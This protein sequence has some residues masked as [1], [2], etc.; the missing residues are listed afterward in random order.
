FREFF[1]EERRSRRAACASKALGSCTG[2]E[3]RRVQGFS[4]MRVAVI[5]SGISGLAAAR[6]LDQAGVATVLFEAEPRFGGHTATVDVTL[7]GVTA[8]VDT[9][10]LVC[11]DHTYPNLLALFAELGVELAS[12]DMSFSVRADAADVEWAGATLASVFAQ[13]ANLFRPR[14]WRFLA[15]ILRFNREATRMVE[16]GAIPEGSVERYLREAGYGGELF[17]WYLWPMVG[18]IWSSPKSEVAEFE[19]AM[20]LR[21]SHNHGLLRINH[22]PRWMTVVGGGRTYVERIVAALPD[23]R[24]ACPVMRIDRQPGGVWVESRHGRERFDHVVFACHSDQALAILGAGAT[25]AERKALGAIRYQPNRCVL[26]TDRS[27]MPRRNTAWSAWNYLQT[28]ADR[29]ADRPVTL[30]YWLNRLQ[31]LPFSRPLFET[32]NPPRDPAPGHLI[33]AFE[34]AHPLLN[35]TAVAAQAEV[36]RLQGQNNTW[37]AGAWLGYG[38]HEDGLKSGLAAARGVIESIQATTAAEPPRLAAE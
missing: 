29:D 22:R 2:H 3:G 25:L 37:F 31:P 27:F 14:F 15:D 23:C 24:L 30:T 26:H 1:A 6:H 4:I 36:E 16:A 10:F 9:G 20:L 13:K 18:S 21:F 19:L 8:P 17:D 11:N 12:S 38:F 5:G 33:A 28:A 35:R 32:L 34:Y 7:D